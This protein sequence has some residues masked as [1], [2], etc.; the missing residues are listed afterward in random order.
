MK[1]IFTHK[2]NAFLKETNVADCLKQ[3][4]LHTFSYLLFNTSKFSNERYNY[5]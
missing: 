4:K 1:A 3:I 2:I 5:T